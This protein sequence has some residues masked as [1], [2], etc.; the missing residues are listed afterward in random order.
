MKIETLFIYLIST[1]TSL[2][3]RNVPNAH[4][5]TNLFADD[6]YHNDSIVNR[7]NS[8]DPRTLLLKL[9][10]VKPQ[11]RT[12][13]RSIKQI[14]QKIGKA[15]LEEANIQGAMISNIEKAFKKSD[16]TNRSN[17]KRTFKRIQRLLG[18]KE[19][20]LWKRKLAKSGITVSKLPLESLNEFVKAFKETKDETPRKLLVGFNNADHST[21]SYK[22][23][24]MS[25]GSL[26]VRFPDL[27]RAIVVNQTP[28]YQ[29][30]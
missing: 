25:G 15:N 4:S 6:R 7:L 18:K 10:T 23:K 24:D 13:R 12:T 14:I 11:Y 29:Y 1:S 5:N 30:T 17:Y 20:K 22:I 21:V 26:S 2:V 3:L 27:P 9:S 28:Y 16:K 8:I 19:F